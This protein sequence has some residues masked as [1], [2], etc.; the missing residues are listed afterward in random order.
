MYLRNFPCKFIKDGK[1]RFVYYTAEAR[2]LRAL[3]WKEDKGKKTA[4]P[5]AAKPEEKAPEPIE[6]PKAVEPIQPPA[7][8]EA[9]DLST[10]TRAELLQY[11]EDRGV[12]LP[13]NALKAELIE[14]CRAIA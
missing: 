10:L 8:L 5:V 3:G 9:P 12:D 2:D 11:A 14:A 13:N 1:S 7:S 4:D 6:E